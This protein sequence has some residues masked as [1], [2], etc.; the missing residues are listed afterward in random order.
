[1]AELRTAEESVKKLR[2]AY[3]DLRDSVCCS[4]VGVAED[5]SSAVSLT[6]WPALTNAHQDDDNSGGG[7]GRRDNNHEGQDGNTTSVGTTNANA[8]AADNTATGNNNNN[9][10]KNNSITQTATAILQALDAIRN[11]MRSLQDKMEKFQKRLQER[12]PVTDKP[13]YGEKTQQRVTQL[14]R[15]YNELNA[16]L[17]QIY[18]EEEGSNDSNGDGNSNQQLSSSGT[19]TSMS[20]NNSAPSSSLDQLK[21]QAEMEEQQRL[22]SLRLQ[23]QAEEEA[24]A[25]AER[26][27]QARLEAERQAAEAAAA[28][29]RRQREQAEEE[30][31]RAMQAERQAAAA[32][33]RADQE[34]M[35]AIPK[36]PDGVRQQLDK[37]LAATAHDKAVQQC[38]ID[39]L[40]TLFSQI[41]ARPEEV[42]FRRIR[43]NHPKFEADIGQHPG[44]KEILIAAGFRLGTIDD[45]PSYISTEPD[46]EKDMD[47][48]GAWF[49]LLKQTLAIIEEAMI[50]L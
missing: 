38:A 10:S 41:V 49:D 32:A 19:G 8:R 13:R 28:E 6:S 44:G 37:L 23:Q 9:N 46:I 14:L 21:K 33:A 47:G 36:G 17:Q 43:R 31:R 34:W 16:I 20:R 2:Q 3:Q 26:E 11:P 48:W 18:G 39:A 40:Y 4:L 15:D 27:R 35:A 42:N 30:A 45:V 25:A 22:H 12:D 24:A 29:Q 7:D 1:M 50:K 5:D